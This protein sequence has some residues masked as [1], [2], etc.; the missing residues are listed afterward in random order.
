[1]M[2]QFKNCNISELPCIYVYIFLQSIEQ[3]ATVPHMERLF[4]SDVKIA[5]QLCI[6]MVNRYYDQAH[7]GNLTGSALG[8]QLL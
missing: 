7:H 8:V 6:S 1:M 2:G 4:P 5:G 3:V